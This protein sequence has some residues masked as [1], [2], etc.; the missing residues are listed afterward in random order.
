MQC[1]RFRGLEMKLDRKFELAFK[2]KKWTSTMRRHPSRCVVCNLLAC[3][4]T[5]AAIQLG[6]VHQPMCALSQ[7]H[8]HKHGQACT[9]N[10]R[11]RSDAD[12]MWQ[13]YRRKNMYFIA[14]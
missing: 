5:Q 8:V 7:Q 2:N 1:G 4:I 10:I 12:S 14:F 9:L 6:C 11:G 13:S 3:P